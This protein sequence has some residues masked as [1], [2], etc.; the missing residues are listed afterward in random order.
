VILKSTLPDQVSLIQIPFALQPKTFYTID[1]KAR[2]KGN[3]TSSTPLIIDLFNTNYDLSQQEA[4]FDN[5]RISQNF[6]DLN[7]VFFSGETVPNVAYLRFFTFSEQPY[8]IKDIALMQNA[9]ISTGVTVSD[10]KSSLS[11]VTPLYNAV[12][13]SPDGIVIYENT[14]FL[15]RVR[16]VKKIIVVVSSQDANNILWNEKNFPPSSI[17]LVEDYNGPTELAYGEV[18]NVDYSSGSNI[19]LSVKTGENGFLVLSDSWYPGWKAY[20]DNQET[21]IYKTNAVSRGILIT[22]AGEHT[23]EFRFVPK[24]FYMGLFVS[25]LTLAGFVLYSFVK[26]SKPKIKKTEGN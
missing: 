21:R 24:S 10:D 15:P 5:S 6:Q 3:V 19:N 22:G 1:F 8:E 26:E 7:V 25:G 16:F 9:N 17:A 23:V 18:V 4:Q 11:D 20:I 12:Y 13:E 2:L 14:R